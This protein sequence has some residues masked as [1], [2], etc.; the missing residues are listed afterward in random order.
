MPA[1]ST[2]R[3]SRQDDTDTDPNDLVASM[4]NLEFSQ[5]IGPVLRIVGSAAASNATAI[6]ESYNS[7]PLAVRYQVNDFIKFAVDLLSTT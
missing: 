3:F 2:Q 6:D 1:N 4:L 7:L 5:V